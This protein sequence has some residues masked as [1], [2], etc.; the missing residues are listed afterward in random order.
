MHRRI[1]AQLRGKLQAGNSKGDRLAAFLNQENC[2]NR[3]RTTKHYISGL[4]Y[5]R[6]IPSFS[7]FAV[8]SK[9]R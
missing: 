8:G 5:S 1:V 3:S 9:T 4:H 7:G 2:F 6:D